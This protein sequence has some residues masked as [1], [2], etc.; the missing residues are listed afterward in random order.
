[1]AND[2]NQVVLQ[3]TVVA[4]PRHRTIGAGRFPVADFRI[5]VGSSKKEGDEW[6]EGPTCFIDVEA[7]GEWQSRDVI[8]KASKGIR[9]MV[10]GKLFLNEWEDR[11][12][13]AK[14]SKHL[15]KMDRMEVLQRF[16]RDGE[17][18][19][20]GERQPRLTSSGEDGDRAK[21]EGQA[22]IPF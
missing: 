8:Q 1:M 17:A 20:F 15:I 22:D 4:D 16:N 3:G 18:I 11:E 9:V 10:V 5:A 6:V 19:P 12:T 13:G 21:P 14:R 2:I 7:F